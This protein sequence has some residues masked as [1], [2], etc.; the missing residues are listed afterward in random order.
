MKTKLTLLLIF[1]IFIFGCTESDRNGISDFS[2][3]E[4]GMSHKDVLKLLGSPSSINKNEDG[5]QSWIY[6]NIKT[7]FTGTK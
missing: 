5:T 7:T 4:L 1:S 2:G 6:F 3:L